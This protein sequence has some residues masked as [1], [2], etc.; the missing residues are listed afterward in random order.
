M[1]AF[2]RSVRNFIIVCV[3][4]SGS[5]IRAAEWQWSVPVANF[6]SP[7]TNDNPRAFLWIPPDCKQVRGVV[8]GQHNMLEEGVF[9]HQA[10]RKTL[11]DIGFAEVWISP[12]F[13]IVFDHRGE[14]E[15]IF[16]E[17]LAALSEVSGYAGLK[18]A[19]VVPFGHSALASYPWNFGAALPQRTLAMISVHGDSPLTDMTGSGLPNPDW[20]KKNIDGIPGLI[21]IGEYEWLEGR[22]LP[23]IAFCEKY[24]KAPLALLADAGHG[25]FDFSD[26][27]VGFLCLFLKKAAD[28]RLP[29]NMPSNSYPSLKPVLPENGWL[30]DRWRKDEPLKAAADKFYTYKGNKKEA[31]WA[32]DK[33]M[34]KATEV[35]Y[36]RA[37]GKAPQYIG[38]MQNGKLL[39]GAGSF[40]GYKL[41]FVPQG[42]GLTFNVSAA[43]TD[44]LQGRKQTSRHAKGKISIS[45]ICGPVQQI[46]DTTFSI[47]FYRMG[48][49]NP[50]RTGDIWL[51]ASMPGDRK[52]KSAVQQANLKIPLK[53]TAG[54]EQKINFP[55]IE[56]Q[57]AAAKVLN[58][59]ASATSGLPVYYYV[60]E[61]PAEISGNTLRFTKIPLKA[62]FPVRVTVVAWQWGRSSAPAIQSA[63]AV[64][65][66]FFIT[67]NS[68]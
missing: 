19:P 2:S 32:F 14:A 33:E 46:N 24:P 55:L 16:E 44:T 7:E 21:V 40:L 8:V 3:L 28:E 42:D 54:S 56:N 41:A 39:E 25:H 45:R 59:D 20:G 66:T 22:I 48:L 18:Y 17:T 1:N 68:Q 53:N 34:A 13:S 35:Y 50:K 62:R 58:L 60:K 49:H 67:S 12:N 26:E 47:R 15:R 4:L 29:E 57:A 6:I 37:R 30:V 11:S 9:E 43:F 63:E 23:G 61:G 27:L 52:Y 64:E 65:R 36:N 31:F 51:M 5:T 10:F 38:Y